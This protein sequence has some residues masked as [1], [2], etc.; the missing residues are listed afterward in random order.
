[1]RGG[2]TNSKLR[3]YFLRRATHL[4]IWIPIDLGLKFMEFFSIV[5]IF[6]FREVRSPQSQNRVRNPCFSMYFLNRNYNQDKS[7]SLTPL[8]SRFWAEL[9]FSV[10]VMTFCAKFY[11]FEKNTQFSDTKTHA[12]KGKLAYHQL[13]LGYFYCFLRMLRTTR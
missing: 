3:P 4:K 1:M 11:E 9:R 13:T 6:I 8:I 2:P 12:S 5:K 10:W 7:K